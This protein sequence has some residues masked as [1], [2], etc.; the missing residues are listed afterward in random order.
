M[1]IIYKKAIFTQQVN[2]HSSNALLMIFSLSSKK[3]CR[4]LSYYWNRFCFLANT[5]TFK[6]IYEFIYLDIELFGMRNTFELPNFNNFFLIYHQIWISPVQVEILFALK[7]FIILVSF[8]H[9]LLK[10]L[11][12][13]FSVK[14][15][16][17]EPKR[18]SFFK[19]FRTQKTMSNGR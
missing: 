13:A 17:K 1:C 16:A 19:K 5:Y 12:K 10:S 3:T 7:R 4:S 11:N 2:L 15:Y 9:F 6:K 14:I 18:N 8:K